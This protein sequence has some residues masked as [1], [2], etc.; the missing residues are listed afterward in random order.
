MS[1]RS[2]AAGA[3]SDEALE[4]LRAADDVMARLIEEHGPLDIEA[5]RRDRP[6]DAYGALL[7]S[8]VGQ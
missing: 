7:R 8:I 4:H 1:P 3:A 2:G 6:A 5:R